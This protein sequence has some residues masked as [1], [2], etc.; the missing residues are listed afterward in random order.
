MIELPSNVKRCKVCNNP[1]EYSHTIRIEN[2]TTAIY[3]CP[4]ENA[5]K[6]D[7]MRSEKKI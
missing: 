2:S 7:L 3:V 4:F 1:L 6:H 5:L